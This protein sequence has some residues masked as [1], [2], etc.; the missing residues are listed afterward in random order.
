[1]A[2]NILNK[3]FLAADQHG[4]DEDPD[5]TVGDLQDLL[6]AAWSLLSP[7][8]QAEFLCSEE[9][10][11]VVLT[12]ARNEFDEE[13]LLT[14]HQQNIREALSKAGGTLVQDATTGQWSYTQVLTFE[15]A[16][17][18]I[19]HAVDSGILDD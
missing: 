1:M 15:T 10:A 19:D 18:A 13:T 4:E 12:G 11:N 6:R 9:V 8:Q 16:Q 3:L 7:S 5:H 17:E 2:T 14:D